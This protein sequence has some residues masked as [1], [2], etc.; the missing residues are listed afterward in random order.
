MLACVSEKF[1]K[2]SV[3]E[4]GINPLY[5]VSLPGYTWQ[6][7]LKYTRINVET[8]QVKNEILFLENNIGSGISAVMADRYIKSDEIKKIL[9]RDANNLY[10]L[11]MSEYLP[12]DEIE[13]DRNVELENIFN[14]LDDGD[15]GYFI[16]VDLE[17]PDIIKEKTKNFPFA[18]EN[19]KI[20]HDIFSD[21][22]KTS[23]PDTFTQTKKLI[24]DW[25][26]KK[27]YLIHYRILN[28]YDRQEMVDEKA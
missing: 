15:V 14:T 27:N 13:F 12:Y 19:K 18:P 21:Y 24:C 9:Y 11:A 26:D 5:C 25:S 2:V 20:N 17:Y 23:K 16:E 6:C 1:I 22:M 7:G 28:F 8:L 3:S 10:G 4:F